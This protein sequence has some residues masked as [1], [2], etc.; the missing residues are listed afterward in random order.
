MEI[1]R[2]KQKAKKEVPLPASIVGE[3]HLVPEVQKHSPIG[4]ENLESHCSTNSKRKGYKQTI[5]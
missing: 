1:N 5:Q 3:V 2:R 4:C